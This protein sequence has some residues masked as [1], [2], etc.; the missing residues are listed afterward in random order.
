M[1]S[2]PTPPSLLGTI[3]A[4]APAVANVNADAL[5][6]KVLNLLVILAIVLAVGFLIYAA[7][8]Y[9]TSAGESGKIEKA[10][11]IITYVFVG[12]AVALLVVPLLAWVLQKLFG[13][14]LPQT[15]L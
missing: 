8:V 3:N 1:T 5:V 6:S 15:I 2:T 7:I 9:V 13:V 10:H 11:K 12:V 4:P 14:S